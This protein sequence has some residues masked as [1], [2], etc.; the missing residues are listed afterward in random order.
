MLRH[1]LNKADDHVL[2]FAEPIPDPVR[3]LAAAE[4]Q[5]LEGI[6]SKLGH[7]PYR[8]GENTGWVKVK[9]RTWRDANR[10]RWEMFERR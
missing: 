6:V 9:C 1:L 3:L 10:G 5:G 7:Q 4:S 8:S 2:S